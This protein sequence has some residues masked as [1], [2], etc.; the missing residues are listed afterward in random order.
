S[1]DFFLKLNDWIFLEAEISV[2]S[3]GA[4]E[5][6]FAQADFIINDW[7]TIIAGKFV[8]PIGWFIERMDNPW[9]NKL[10]SDPLTAMQVLPSFSLLG[11]Q[12]RGAFYHGC[13]PIKMEYAAYISNG[14]NLTPEAGTPNI[15]ELANIQNMTDTENIISNEKA[16]GGRIG[17]WYPEVGLEVGLSG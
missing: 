4:V 16:F 11:V 6:P 5:A 1:P 3:G 7:L 2:G 8:A 10:P 15:N 14:L 13:S 9:I 12:A 17:F